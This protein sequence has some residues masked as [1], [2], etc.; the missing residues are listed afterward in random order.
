VLQGDADEPSVLLE[1]GVGPPDVFVAATG[2]DEDNLVACLLAK[3]EYR[4]KKVIAAVR[5]PRNAG[6]TTAAGAWTRL[7]IGAD[8][9]PA[10]RRGGDAR[11]PGHA[12]GPARGRDHD[13]VDHGD[14]DGVLVGKTFEELHVPPDCHPAA[15]IR[16]TASSCRDRMCVSGPVT[17]CSSSPARAE[18]VTSRSS[19]EGRLRGGEGPGRSPRPRASRVSEVA[20]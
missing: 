11:R 18:S 2:D 1:A 19:A 12:A 15:V 5:N 17:S 7:W 9:G 16:T 20:Q 10:H 13:Y 3:N 4:V 14:T 8:R 6:F